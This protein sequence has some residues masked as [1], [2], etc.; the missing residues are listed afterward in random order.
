MAAEAEAAREAR[1]K[2]RD[3]VNTFDTISALRSDNRF[4]IAFAVV[5]DGDVE[6][7]RECV[8]EEKEG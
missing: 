6:R 4:L 3:V 5:C 2:V 7:E 1:A 8:R